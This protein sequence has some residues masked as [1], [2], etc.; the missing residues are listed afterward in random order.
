MKKLI[1]ILSLLFIASNAFA[2]GAFYSY[3]ETTGGEPYRWK[4]GKT[5]WKYDIGRFSKKV[6]VEPEASHVEFCKSATVD[7]C[8]S[9]MIKCGILKCVEKKFKEWSDAKMLAGTSPTKEVKVANLSF[10]K[11]GPMSHDVESSV[12]DSDRNIYQ[13]YDKG[14]VKNPMTHIIFDEDGSILQDIYGEGNKPPL[15]LTLLFKDAKSPYYTGGMV[16][17]NGLAFD[18]E[19]G[20]DVKELASAK[21]V[22]GTIL[23]ELGHLI[24]LDHTQPLRDILG[25]SETSAP[26]KPNFVPTMYPSNIDEEQASLKNDDKSGVAYIYWDEGTTQ[27]FKDGFCRIEGEVKNAS[28]GESYQGVNVVAYTDGDNIKES[29]KYGGQISFVSGS[30]YYPDVKDVPLGKY[31]IVGRMGGVPTKVV[32]QAIMS[33]WAGSSESGFAGS[34]NPYGVGENSDDWLDG[35][36]EALFAKD[37]NTVV[38]EGGKTCVICDLVK[39]GSPKSSDAYSAYQDACEIKEVSLMTMRATDAPAP[40]ESKEQEENSSDS[41]KKGFC[42][43]L[44]A[45]YNPAWGAVLPVLVGLLFATRRR[46]QK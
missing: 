28:T 17:L 33:K 8:G 35:P 46:L 44:A 27:E 45:P 12:L 18:G 16:I 13:E 30:M 42:M 14:T 4:N 15:G 2:Y 11:I 32:M 36:S 39:D 3:P 34:I 29:E 20:G 37:G 40:A 23:H 5:L 10:I 38:S 24:G 31:V 9:E 25:A 6:P 41:P 43:S 21:Y 7:P 26:N 22:S 19:T 1:L